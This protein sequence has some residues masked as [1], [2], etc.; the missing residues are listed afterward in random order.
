MFSL[1]RE[2]AWC[3]YD[4]SRGPQPLVL[5]KTFFSSRMDVASVR[6]VAGLALSAGLHRL[7]ERQ[8]KAKQNIKQKQ[9]GSKRDEWKREMVVFCAPLIP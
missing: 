1:C 8:S 2:L 6:Q 3:A 7:R 4:C 9:G 5:E